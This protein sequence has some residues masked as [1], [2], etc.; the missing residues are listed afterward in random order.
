MGG[1]G[2][3]NPSG[4]GRWPA[5]V[6]LDETAAAALDEQSG[7]AKPQKARV[8]VAND[9]DPSCASFKTRGH[10]GR[11]PEDNGGGASRFFYVS[12]A[13][14]SEREAGLDHLR[15]ASAGELTGGRKE[16]S[17]GLHNPRAGAGRTSSGRAN[18]HPT[19]KPIALM[20]YLVRLV[21]PPGG[22]VLD[23]YTGSGTTGIA[24]VL[25]GF[26]FLGC[27]LSDEYCTIARARIAHHEPR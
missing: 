16:G 17:A 26:S 14:K 6:L 10:A 15:K 7:I 4:L 12:K 23:P 18:T 13:S 24:A 25:E 21:T 5:N 20:R 22:L 27:E 1:L 11:V 8:A 9:S 2:F 19:V 3:E